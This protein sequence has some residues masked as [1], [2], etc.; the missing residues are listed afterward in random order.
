MSLTRGVKSPKTSIPTPMTEVGMLAFTL[1]GGRAFL[2]LAAAAA[3]EQA[4]QRE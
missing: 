3:S 4:R 1:E 2:A